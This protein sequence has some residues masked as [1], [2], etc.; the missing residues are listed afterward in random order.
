M[1]SD[2]EAKITTATRAARAQAR[3]YADSFSWPINRDLEELGVLQSL[4]AS[5]DA[6]GTLF[7]SDLTLRGRSNDPPD[8]EALNPQGLRIAF[9][10]TEL[11]NPEAIRSHQAG[12]TYEFAEWPREKFHLRLA[13]LLLRKDARYPYL[14]GAPHHGGYMVVIFT[15]EPRL[16]RATVETLLKTWK[17]PVVSYISMQPIY[18]S[19][20][21][22]AFNAIH[23]LLCR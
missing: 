15:D 7:F 1:T 12:N 16:P 23:T 17:P 5:L 8:C 6:E 19:L 9:E 21:M 2:E 3:G 22:P 11:V 10:V 20:M 14:K 4:A 18:Y 13:E